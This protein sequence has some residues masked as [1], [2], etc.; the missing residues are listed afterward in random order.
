MP[1]KSIKVTCK[2]CKGQ[3]LRFELIP[4]HDECECCGVTHYLNLEY[5]CKKCGRIT[6]ESIERYYGV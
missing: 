4:E 5:T 6:E 3:I 2:K 1:I